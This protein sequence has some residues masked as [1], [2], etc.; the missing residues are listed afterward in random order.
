MDSVAE[1]LRRHF[2]T[3][4]QIVRLFVDDLHDRFPPVQRRAR[5][6]LE[7]Y[8]E[9]CDAALGA[10]RADW[11][12]SADAYDR[13]DLLRFHLR[14]LNYRASELED[15]FA[16]ALS[17]VVP[18]ALVDA[19][20]RE[21]EALLTTPR[22]VILSIG[23]ADNYETLITELQDIVL[24]AL[25]PHRP[26]LGGE[27]RDTRF[28]LVRLP[29][30]ESGEPSWRPLILGHEVAHLALIERA[31]VSS[32][33]IESR[34]DSA[35]S[36]HLLEVPR[37]LAN[38]RST[39]ALAL[40]TVGE[41]WVE[42]LICDAYAVRRFGPAAVAALGG[43]FELVG[44]FDQLGDHPPGWL[45]CRLLVHWLGEIQSAR[46]DA[47]VAPW[48]ELAAI[49]PPSMPDWANYLCT[50]LWDARDD[51][52]PLIVDWPAAYDVNL[53]SRTVEWI[54]SELS[55]GV[56]R[57]DVVGANSP[58]VVGPLCD[59]DM[60][61]AG[62]VAR[63]T[64]T[65]MPTDRLVE[66]SLESLDFVR[67]WSDAGGQLV[68]L[69]APADQEDDS[70]SILS[71]GAIRSR[72]LTADLSKR[73]VVSPGGLSAI[74]GASIDVRLAKHFI[75]FERSSTSALSAA[76]GGARQM[77]SAVEKSWDD[78]FVLHPG[79]LVLASTLEYLVLPSDL[80]A[81]VVTRSSYGRLGL[82]TATAIFVHP[83]F[84]GALTLELVNLG[85]VPLALQPGERIAQL[86]LQRISPP[87]QYPDADDK[88]TCNTRPEFSRVSRDAEMATLRA[89]SR[90]PLAP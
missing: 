53:R 16:G 63:Q 45:R 27:L 43:F 62:W 70:G 66:K 82:I 7:L 85:Q 77:Q 33:D 59:S 28:A 81:T 12:N 84:K 31:T 79:E 30:L 37:H 71:E 19:V 67:R 14:D 89:M 58:A 8:R 88:Y 26:H 48:R 1:E 15:W 44:G 60:I 25:G 11:T 69:Q 4:L 5:L 39:P 42:E 64:P 54:G 87:K 76:E 24:G 56:A 83:W 20:E 10:V 65:A 90:Y 18:P 36:D 80:A 35:I 49:P 55:I 9:Y 17:E 75:V 34:L 57:S 3:R 73:L 2:E 32:F 78:H 68:E 52:M 13:V 47:V 50:V 22:Q 21:L 51:V 74:R 29:R 61:N 86:V 40:K 72:L 23:S 41:E 6:A 38:L 46:I